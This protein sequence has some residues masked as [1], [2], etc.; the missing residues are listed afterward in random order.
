MQTRG[1]TPSLNRHAQEIR[2]T[3]AG[4]G[5]RYLFVGKSRAIIL[6]SPDTAQ[7]ADDG[8]AG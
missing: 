7:D 1:W 6:G 2:D 5:V 3:V 4:P 8:R